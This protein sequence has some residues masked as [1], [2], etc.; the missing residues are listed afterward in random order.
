MK[1]RLL[2]NLYYVLNRISIQIPPLRSRKEDIPSIVENLLVKLNQ[3]FGM[4]IEK[5]TEEAQNGLKQYDW[6]GNVTRTRKCT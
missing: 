2:K 6:P 4:N 3:E 1:V 5:I